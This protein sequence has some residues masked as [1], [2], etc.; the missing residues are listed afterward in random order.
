MRR[1]PSERTST[2]PLSSRA[3]RCCDTAGRLIGNWP[4]T[5]GGYRFLP[6]PRMAIHVDTPSY[7]QAIA[8]HIAELTVG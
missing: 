8:S 6:Q 2:S 5:S 3:F 1:V 7:R 4:D